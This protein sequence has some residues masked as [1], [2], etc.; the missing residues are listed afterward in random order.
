MFK[1]QKNINSKSILTKNMYTIKDG[2]DKCNIKLILSMVGSN[3]GISLVEYKT[4]VTDYKIVNLIQMG[5]GA[6]V[7]YESVLYMSDTVKKLKLLI[8]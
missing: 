1:L 8:K 2:Y 6:L 7:I 5:V 3:I 4:G